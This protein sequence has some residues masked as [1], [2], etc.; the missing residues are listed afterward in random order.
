MEIARQ[1]EITVID[2]LAGKACLVLLGVRPGQNKGFVFFYLQTEDAW[3]RFFIHLGILFWA[4][5][6]PDP[7]DDLD[8]DEVYENIFA[9]CG[10]SGV[11][12]IATLAMADGKL[13][14]HFASGQKFEISENDQSDGMIASIRQ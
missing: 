7:E 4:T 3:Y 6:P 13:T 11:Q 2:E 1:H 12:V 10:L 9:L 5:R 14:F 8:H